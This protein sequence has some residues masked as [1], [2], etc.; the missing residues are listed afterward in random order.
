MPANLVSGGGR[1]LEP[2]L[3][4]F[5]YNWTMRARWFDWLQARPTELVTRQFAGGLHSFANNLTHIIGAE[6]RWVERMRGQPATRDDFGPY[7]SLEAVR[8]LDAERR[9]AVRAFLAGLRPEDLPRRC[10]FHGRTLSWQT[11]LLHAATHEVHHIGQLY[12]WAREAGVEPPS[13]AL[14]EID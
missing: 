2:F 10:E 6:T 4:L 13:S 12:V 1:G 11:V 7:Q 9:P 14:F 5:R 3:R 8:R